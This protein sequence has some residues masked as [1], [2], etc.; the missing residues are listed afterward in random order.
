MAADPRKLLSNVEILETLNKHLQKYQNLLTRSI[1]QTHTFDEIIMALGDSIEK[2]IEISDKMTQAAKKLSTKVIFTSGA[3]KGLSFGLKDAFKIM[4][5]G[6]K[7]IESIA[8]TGFGIV[9]KII[10]GLID[11]FRTLMQEVDAYY[12]AIAA[13]IEQL[14]N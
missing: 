12:K 4:Q 10:G 3:I 2:A 14:R 9:N 8:N 11:G 1:G 5:F 13:S 7:G 6:I